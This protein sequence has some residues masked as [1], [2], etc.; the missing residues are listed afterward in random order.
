MNFVDG[1]TS[2]IQT[3]L[4]AKA[5]TSTLASYALKNGSNTSG[6]WPISISGNASSATKLATARSIWGQTFDGTQGVDGHLYLGSKTYR[7]YF[8]TSGLTSFITG[9]DSGYLSINS[10]N[11]TSAVATLLRINL[12]NGV[13]SGNSISLSNNLA[14]SGAEGRGITYTGNDIILKAAT[15]GWAMGIEPYHNDDTTSFSHSVGGA[16]GGDANTINYT[17]YGGTYN[18]PAMVILPNKMVG[19]GTTS[20]SY[21]LDVRGTGYFSG[22]LTAPGGLFGLTKAQADK[23]AENSNYYNLAVGQKSSSMGASL[24]MYRDSAEYQ[25]Y[26]VWSTETQDHIRIGLAADSN[27]L[28][29]KNHKAGIQLEG[30]GNLTYNGYPLLHSANYTSYTVTK[31]GGGASG[32]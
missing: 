29:I 23:Y 32:T 8:G 30:T 7:L 21:K 24:L 10:A 16:Y 25:S 26:I 22:V 6:T 11:N 1:V 20:P 17:Y 2:N 4:N 19:I 9:E 14:V 18:S 3:Q 13:I 15:G 28:F 31:T 12:S 5:N 27:D